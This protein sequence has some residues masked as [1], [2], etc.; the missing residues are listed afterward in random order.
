MYQWYFEINKVLYV[1]NLNDFI[2]CKVAYSN[3]IEDWLNTEYIGS[4]VNKN[5]ISIVIICF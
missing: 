3:A 4:K 1:L 2:V 5:L